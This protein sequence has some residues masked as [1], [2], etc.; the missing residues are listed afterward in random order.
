MT[1][2]MENFVISIGRQP[3]SGGM[4]I[5]ERLAELLNVKVYDKKLLEVAA[6]ESGL[7][8]T[9]FEMADEQESSGFFSGMF[10]IHGSM[11]NYMPGGS[12]MEKDKLFE[13]QS[14]AIRHISE[15]ENCIIVGRCAEY[16]LRDHPRMISIFITADNNDRIERIMK[17]EGLEYD[18]AIDFME[19]SDK[20]RKSYHDYYTT[21]HWGE[22]RSYDIC[23]NSSR[24]GIE[25]TAE[26]LYNF[27]KQHFAE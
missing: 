11:S 27:I 10:S 19:K 12:C 9:V 4:L 14:E 21:T 26:F 17:V 23:V 13:I 5:A 1:L 22:A 3:G 6:V 8:T 2:F 15:N 25:G 7:D 24:M 16:I 20:P 18:K